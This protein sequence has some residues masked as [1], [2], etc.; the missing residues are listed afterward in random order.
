MNDAEVVK[1]LIKNV[2][3]MTI[4]STTDDGKPWVSPVSFVWDDDYNLYWVSSRESH[5]SDYIRQ[6]PDVSIVVVGET[7]EGK[8]DGVYFEATAEQIEDEAIM[9]KV[10]NLLAER[11]PQLPKFK[12]NSLADI[13]GEAAW[14]IYKATP[15]KVWKRSDAEL[16][17]Q[18]ITVRKEVELL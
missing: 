15:S 16:Y 1:D 11:R 12:I 10:M 14:R 8:M 13:S 4:A 17:G 5:H 7:S 9:T 18:A 3:L 6:R 2:Q